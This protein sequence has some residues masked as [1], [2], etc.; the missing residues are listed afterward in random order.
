MTTIFSVDAAA[1]A[2]QQESQR[3][4]E[5]DFAHALAKH[6]AQAKSAQ[7]EQAKSNQSPSFE[8]APTPG[9]TEPELAVPRG[10]NGMSLPSPS[11]PLAMLSELPQVLQAEATVAPTGVTEALLSARVFGWHAMAQAYLSELTAADH[12]APQHASAT[13]SQTLAAGNASASEATPAA[14]ASTTLIAETAAVAP[15]AE[16]TLPAPLRQLAG[17]SAPS[18]TTEVAAAEVSPA[19]NWSERSLRFTRQ[20]DGASVAWLRDFRISDDEASRL[21]QFV[22]SDARAKGIALSKIMLNGR[23]AWT[24]PQSH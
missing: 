21:I 10:E 18:A 8:Q 5:Q 11:M 17:D 19:A 24:S 2:Q 12:Q 14:S 13:T 20:H 7:Q 4:P 23:E 22:L 3:T 15:Q 16:T 6:D 1:Q 9:T